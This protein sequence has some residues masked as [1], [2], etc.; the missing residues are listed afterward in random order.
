MLGVSLAA[1]SRPLGSTS[2]SRSSRPAQSA[3]PSS[4]AA[5]SAAPSELPSLGPVALS[6]CSAGA[7]PTLG[8][9]ALL[10]DV[11]ARCVHGMAALVRDPALATLGAGRSV[12][13]SFSLA[14][15]T[16]CIQVAAAGDR[17]IQGLSVRIEDDQNRVVEQADIRGRV[18]LIGPQGP[19]CLDQAGNYRVTATVTAGT[20]AVALM[21]WQAE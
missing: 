13:L 9:A 4:S 17:G 6:G 21:A 7:D 20:G 5:P 18:A 1:C 2:P 8:A 15:Q 19:T 10:S 11:G 3:A 16:R 12:S 14:D